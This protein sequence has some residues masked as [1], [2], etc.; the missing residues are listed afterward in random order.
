MQKEILLESENL[1]P[2]DIAVSIKNATAR[3]Q[4]AQKKSPLQN[5][6]SK[7]HKSKHLDDEDELEDWKRATLANLNCD[8]PKGKLIGIIGPVGAGKYCAFKILFFSKKNSVKTIF[9]FYR[10][11]LIFTSSVA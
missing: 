9:L 4:I 2:R 7:T 5:G 10:K 8:F 11:K 6:T 3:W 1:A